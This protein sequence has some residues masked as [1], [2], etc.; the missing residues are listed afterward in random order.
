MLDVALGD[1]ALSRTK[2]AR[3]KLAAQLEANG[4]RVADVQSARNLLQLGSQCCGRREAGRAESCTRG[5][6]CGAMRGDFGAVAANGFLELSDSRGIGEQ[7]LR[8]Q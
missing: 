7:L 3:E 2:R 8:S 4:T 1:G 5:L 6:Q